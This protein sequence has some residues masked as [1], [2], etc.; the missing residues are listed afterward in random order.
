MSPQA[1]EGLTE[2]ELSTGRVSP[3]K[4]N[5][6]FALGILK[7]ILDPHPRLARTVP[8]PRAEHSNPTTRQCHSALEPFFPEHWDSRLCALIDASILTCTVAP[9]VWWLI[10][11]PLD[12]LLELRTRHL[13]GFYESIEEERRRLAG[14]LHDGVGQLLTMI[15]SGLRSAA[16]DRSPQDQ[17]QRVLDL[18][19]IAYEALGEVKRINLGL[20]PTVLDDL[21]LVAALSRLAEDLQ[22]HHGLAISVE[23]AT[24]VRRRLPPAV[25]IS[26]YR[27][28]QEALNNV[29]KH[30][31]ASSATVTLTIRDDY[32]L[33]CVVDDGQGVDQR[34]R[35]STASDLDGIG[36]ISMK[37][38]ATLLGG[39][40]EIR[41][42]D[43]RGTRI[44]AK[45]PL[46]VGD[47]A[48][49]SHPTR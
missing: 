48:D 19:R 47:D 37:E 40:I 28:V 13:R 46:G 7:Q 6:G 20:R 23:A 38:R 14:E 3:I 2:G 24:L 29:V 4:P 21:G 35:D 33:A 44:V 26:C 45:L 9:V 10:V 16:E 18:Q 1:K 32:L 8:K 43:K 11:R 42:G 41:S 49:D 17:H 31:G 5:S 36:L 15:V 12:A 25:E 22:R 34:T 30:A 39:H 27:I